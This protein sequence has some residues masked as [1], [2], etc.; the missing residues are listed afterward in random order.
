M[1]EPHLSKMLKATIRNF[2]TNIPQ[3]ISYIDTEI[4]LQPWERMASPRFVSDTEA[5]INLMSL[6]RDLMGHASIP[7]MFGRAILEKYPD[8]L[9]DIYEM[10]K[11]MMFF[12]IGLPPWF[13][14]PGVLKAHMARMRIWEAL[15]DQQEAMDA[16]VDGKD[17]DYMWGD[18]DDVSD[19]I[20]KR[21]AMF[22]SKLTANLPCSSIPRT[23]T[24][25][26][27]RQWLRD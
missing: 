6:L 22:K 5:E 9:Q 25:Y 17:V 7:A 13:P 20:W 24:N 11:G 21:H 10:D 18:L 23:N 4:D 14:W 1:K 2:E 8:L 27:F 19:F 15:D 12:L 16:A 3:M 26:I